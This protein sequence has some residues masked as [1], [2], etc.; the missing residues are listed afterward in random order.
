MSHLLWCSQLNESLTLVFY[1]FYSSCWRVPLLLG[2]SSVCAEVPTYTALVFLKY[3]GCVSETQVPTYNNLVFLKHKCQLILLM[4]S[5]N[6]WR[7][8]HEMTQK[9]TDLEICRRRGRAP[10]SRQTQRGSRQ[11]RHRPT[12]S[13]PWDN[14]QVY[15]IRCCLTEHI[16]GFLWRR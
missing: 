9:D 5:W 13:P 15:N 14:R 7:W 6:K 10:N 1:A 3:N 4:W 12:T 8:R 16:K 2:G 11:W